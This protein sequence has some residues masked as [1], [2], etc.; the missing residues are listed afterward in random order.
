[1]TWKSK[2]TLAV[3]FFLF[4]AHSAQA[5]TVLTGVTT[6]RIG[7]DF[8]IELG[9]NGNISE[10]NVHLD[11][12]LDGI[13]VVVNGATAGKR[14]FKNISD[15]TVKEVVMSNN[16]DG[17]LK[18][19]VDLAK[20]LNA[21]DFQ[22]STNY[23]IQTNQILIRVGEPTVAPTAVTAAA[24]ADQ[25]GELIDK[26]MKQEDSTGAVKVNSPNLSGVSKAA[27]A[28]ADETTPLFKSPQVETKEKSTST[29]GLIGRMIASLLLV[30]AVFGGGLYALKKWPGAKKLAS[31][32]R[33][34]EI[35][36]QHSLGPKRSV[37]VIRVAGETVLVGVTDSHI[38]ILKSLSLLDEDKF[39]A[40]LENTV[41][42]TANAQNSRVAPQQEDD[43]AMRGLKEI[44]NDRL[45]NMRNFS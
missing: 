1:M 32:N 44:V 6:K 35:L 34:I 24:G 10:Q 30:A 21:R 16:N 41:S 43:F 29:L 5:S 37:A 23:V 22:K 36:A 12:M 20:N 8:F 25:T 28:S 3:L 38:N 39:Q 18:L 19:H 33:M 2:S 13:N 4:L 40:A 17:N 15:E 9:F 7:T 45:K 11:Y 31:R 14:R 26:L 27:A 42:K